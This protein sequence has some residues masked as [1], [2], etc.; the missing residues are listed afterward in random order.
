MGVQCLGLE[1]HVWHVTCWLHSGGRYHF[2]YSVIQFGIRA[3][4]YHAYV[5]VQLK[6]FEGTEAAQAVC[7]LTCLVQL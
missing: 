6:L 7:S 3:V 5:V 2:Y 4:N 1:A